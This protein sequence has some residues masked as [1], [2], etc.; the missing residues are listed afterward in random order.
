[1]ITLGTTRTNL[2]PFSSTTLF[3]SPMVL[4]N[5]PGEL[6][7]LQPLEFTQVEVIGRPVINVTVWGDDLEDFDESITLEVYQRSLRRNLNLMQRTIPSVVRIDLSVALK[8]G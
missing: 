7:K 8:S 6:G 5:C 3:E 4:L 2:S 1:M